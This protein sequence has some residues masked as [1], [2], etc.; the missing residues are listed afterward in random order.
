VSPWAWTHAQ[1]VNC[2]LERENSKQQLTTKNCTPSGRKK[3]QQQNKQRKKGR[4]KKVKAT[5]VQSKKNL[6]MKTHH[7][8]P[9]QLALFAVHSHF[10]PILKL[11]TSITESGNQL[12]DLL[13]LNPR[14]C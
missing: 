12:Q 8:K 4:E 11:T 1:R 10:D 14:W 2:T 7:G 9:C 3:Q 13:E 6:V 5:E